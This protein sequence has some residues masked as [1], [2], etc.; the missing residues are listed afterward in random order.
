MFALAPDDEPLEH[1]QLSVSVLR[2]K[3]VITL[4][5]LTEVKPH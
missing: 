1:T 5:T 3:E 4:Q 2:K